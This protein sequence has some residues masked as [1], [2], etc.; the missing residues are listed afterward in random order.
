[1]SPSSAKQT[2]V[3]TFRDDGR[4]FELKPGISLRRGQFGLGLTNMKERAAS[5]GG[6]CE[7]ESL[8]TKGTAVIV[9]IP[10]Q[11]SAEPSRD[12]ELDPANSVADERVFALESQGRSNGFAL[13]TNCQRA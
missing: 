2:L 11:K 5:L 1:M 4:A 3:L 7:I 6:T 13:G 8:P 12:A 10:M 9:Q